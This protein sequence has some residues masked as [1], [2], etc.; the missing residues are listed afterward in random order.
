MFI[1]KPVIF[2]LTL[3]FFC[4]TLDACQ[5][6]NLTSDSTAVNIKWKW[7]KGKVLRYKEISEEQ[8]EAEQA[9]IKNGYKTTS[10]FFSKNN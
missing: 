7:E 2:L 10:V 3:L 9:K 6:S 8:L 1:N 4:I 5:I